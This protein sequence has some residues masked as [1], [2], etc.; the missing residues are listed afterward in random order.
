M[1]HQT[2]KLH[3]TCV[4]EHS[5]CNEKYQALM[6]TKHHIYIMI[7]TKHHDIYESK[8]QVA[9]TV[10]ELLYNSC[11]LYMGKLQTYKSSERNSTRAN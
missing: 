5:L 4:C 10:C 9:S 2:L 8:Y 1:F 7:F 3:V 11:L 6:F